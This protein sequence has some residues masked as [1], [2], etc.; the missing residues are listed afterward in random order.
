MH[1]SIQFLYIILRKS[2]FMY[3]TD[4]EDHLKQLNIT[5]TIQ[6]CCVRRHMTSIM[7]TKMSINYNSDICYVSFWWWLRVI[8]VEGGASSRNKPIWLTSYS[9]LI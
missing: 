4:Y 6:Y 3:H 1:G 9:H 7:S 2:R 8:R 5:S